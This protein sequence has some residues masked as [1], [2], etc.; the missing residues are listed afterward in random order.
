MEIPL[1]GEVLRDMGLLTSQQ[2][3]QILQYQARTRQRFGQTAI[4]LGI[5][6]RE[7]VWLAWAVQLSYRRE[8]VDPRQ[9][10]IDTAALETVGVS[11]ARALRVV[12]LRLWG[13]HLV[14]AVAPED[15]G[16]A[17][18]T[19]ARE[20]GCQVHCC[21]AMPESLQYQLDHLDEMALAGEPASECVPMCG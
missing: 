10:G 7:Q 18:E 6:T 5:A 4:R 13:N 8:F 17:I 14:V 21:M 12:P 20:T 19:L 11:R 15:D 2:I 16:S 3:I 9:M 1:I